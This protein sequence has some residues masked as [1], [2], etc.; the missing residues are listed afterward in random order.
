[1]QRI[2]ARWPA[3]GPPGFDSLCAELDQEAQPPLD[4]AD[5][6][7]VT[8]D[9]DQRQWVDEGVVIRRG[10]FP[11]EILDPYIAVRQRLSEFGDAALLGGWQ[12]AN[13]YM[14]V[15]E[16]RRLS[17]YP[18]M[19][20]LLERLFGRPAMLIMNLTNWISSDRNWHQDTYLNPAHVGAWHVA[21]WIALGDI[22][23]D[24]GPF[25]YVPGSHRWP[26]LSGDKVRQTLP[27]AERE[28]RS[29]SG[30]EVWPTLTQDMLASVIDREIARTGLPV[31][32]FLGSKGDLLIWHGR[33]MHRGSTAA[34]PLMERRSLIAH[35]GIVGKRPDMAT[36]QDENG[37]S[38][39]LNTGPLVWADSRGDKILLRSKDYKSTE[40][41]NAAGP[42]LDS[43]RP[44]L[45]ASTSA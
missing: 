11:D 14:H 13:S 1:M 21:V 22:H 35:Y 37:C 44:S 5:G 30:A 32:T 3:G 33:L 16:L 7:L 2:F 15:P 45:P 39:F 19:M 20:G 40:L 34:K 18:P 8:L 4:R 38:F 28:R 42:V 17:L 6:S 24:S 10:F 25:Q 27:E 9:A 12:S 41:C 36:A 43:A 26:M 31:R 23:P 29:E